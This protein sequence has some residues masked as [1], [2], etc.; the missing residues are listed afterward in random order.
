MSGDIKRATADQDRLHVPLAPGGGS[1]ELQ[2]ARAVR[3]RRATNPSGERLIRDLEAD[4]VQYQVSSDALG[5]G[6]TVRAR[7]VRQLGAAGEVEEQDLGGTG[8]GTGPVADRER[9]RA[10]AGLPEPGE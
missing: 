9:D 6:R 3:D 1:V 7:L 5:S 10:R 8:A 2:R 4:V